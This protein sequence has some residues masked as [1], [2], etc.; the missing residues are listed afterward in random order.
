MAPFTPFRVTMR[1][2]RQGA[3]ASFVVW[4]APFGP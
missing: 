1:E 2:T 4:A 3:N